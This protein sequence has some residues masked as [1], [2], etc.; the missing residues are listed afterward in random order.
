VLD[1][2]R[3]TGQIELIWSVVLVSSLIAVVGFGRA[4]SIVFWKAKSVAVHDGETQTVKTPNVMSYVAIGGLI[5]LLAALSVLG[6]FVHN[7]TIATADQLF[8]PAPYI[9][10]VTQ[11]AG[12]LSSPSEGH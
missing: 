11:T 7:Y 12:K 8:D 10:V 3:D 1:A 4:G 2:A 6:G 5:A 9:E